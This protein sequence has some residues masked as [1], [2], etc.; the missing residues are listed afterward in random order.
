MEILYFTVTG[1]VLYLGSDWVLNRIEEARGKRF[2]HRSL[3]FFIIIFSL[4]V[5]LFSGMRA[6]TQSDG[7][8]APMG[9]DP[10][11]MVQPH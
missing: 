11:P 2:P 4:S 5:P 1:A 9:G 3:I 10:P 8:Q 7:M 6:L